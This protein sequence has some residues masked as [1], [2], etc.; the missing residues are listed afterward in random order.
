MDTGA[1]ITTIPADIDTVAPYA[2]EAVLKLWKQGLLNGDGKNF[3]PGSN[4]SR[5]RRPR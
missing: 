5:A 3:N 1:N 2:R 4:A